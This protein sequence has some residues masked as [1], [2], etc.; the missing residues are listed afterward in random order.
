MSVTVTTPMSN[1]THEISNGASVN[2]NADGSLVVFDNS[3]NSKRIAVF[4]PQHWRHAKVTEGPTAAET[5]LRRINEYLDRMYDQTAGRTSQAAE[6]LKRML[7][8]LDEIVSTV[9]L[10]KEQSTSVTY[11]TYVSTGTEDAEIAARQGARRIVKDTP[12]A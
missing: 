1:E 8:D 7:D 5:A 2:V 12:Q 9:T 6:P 4:A 3:S 11:N 10:P